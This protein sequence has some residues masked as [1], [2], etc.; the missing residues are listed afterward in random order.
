VLGPH[1]QLKRIVGESI[2]SGSADPG[3]PVRP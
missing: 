2:R 1:R 3:L